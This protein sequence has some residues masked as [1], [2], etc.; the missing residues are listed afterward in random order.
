MIT[1]II[2]IGFIITNNGEVPLNWNVAG[3]ATSYG[4]PLYMLILPITSLL[5]V[6]LLYFT[7]KIDPKGE[8]IRKSG[9]ILAIIM[10]LIAI[11]MLGIQ[12][13]I[14]AAINGADILQLTTF[15]SLFMGL[16]F[17]VIGYFTPRIKPNYMLGIR[18]P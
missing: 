4:S 9:P 1:L 13:I 12:V 17:I 6:P 2:T 3:E 16:L 14:I 11:L 7:P 8:N 15:I 10:F 5:I 18:T